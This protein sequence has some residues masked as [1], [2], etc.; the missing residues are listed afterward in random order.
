MKVK[1]FTASS[2]WNLEA[3]INAFLQGIGGKYVSA[4]SFRTY[5]ANNTFIRKVM[6]LEKTDSEKQR[7][8][9][10]IEVTKEAAIEM[11]H[12]PAT[13]RNSYLFTPLKDLYLNEPDKFRKMF[14][15]D[16]NVALSRF[17]TQNTA[18]H[19]EIPANWKKK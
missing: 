13:F 9:N 14:N 8:K 18:K 17:I 5:H 4:K 16:I 2:I 7:I 15:K 19:A 11:H 6:A 10:L 1:L 3:D 12:N